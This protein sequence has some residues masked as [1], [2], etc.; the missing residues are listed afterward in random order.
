MKTNLIS[1]AFVIIS[2][3]LA[4]CVPSIYPFYTSDDIV[5]EESL[6]GTWTEEDL[7]T[8][9]FTTE[10]NKNYLLEL[11]ENEPDSP[12][13]KG[14]FD[15]HLFKIGDSHFLDLIPGVNDQMNIPFLM[16]LSML[17]MHLLFK[18]DF[19]GETVVFRLMNQERCAEMIEKGLISVKHE[20]SGDL[21][22]LSA[23]T[24]ELQR[25][26]IEFGKDA[27]AYTEEMVLKK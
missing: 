8:W 22:V 12:Q 3:M 18:V 24:D 14:Y 5:F 6:L 26:V 2:L 10:N 13:K 16:K 15:V 23:P 27:E 9:N 20:K 17:P 7:S 1:L 21:I 25:F 11:T 4:G 19:M